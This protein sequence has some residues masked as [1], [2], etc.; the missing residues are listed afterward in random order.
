MTIHGHFLPFASLPLPAPLP[1]KLNIEK[2]EY[3]FILSKRPTT[4]PATCL[5]TSRY[6][7]VRKYRISIVLPNVRYPVIL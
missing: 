1:E 7:P 2:G 6:S 5:L 3:K 4:T